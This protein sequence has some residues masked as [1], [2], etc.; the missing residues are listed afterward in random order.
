M[1]DLGTGTGPIEGDANAYNVEAGDYYVRVITGPA[2]DCP[3]ELTLTP[4]GS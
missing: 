3:W 2:P 4:A 1:V